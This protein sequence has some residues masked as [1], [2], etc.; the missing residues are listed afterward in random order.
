V[1]TREPNCFIVIGGGAIVDE[2]LRLEILAKR[3]LVDKEAR[4][5]PSAITTPFTGTMFKFFIL[6]SKMHLIE[7]ML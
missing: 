5:S 7:P 1:V 4:H 3:R 6:F 2:M